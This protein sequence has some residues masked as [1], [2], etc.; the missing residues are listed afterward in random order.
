[1]PNDDKLSEEG[2]PTRR[3]S[4]SPTW[5]GTVMSAKD[6]QIEAIKELADDKMAFMVDRLDAEYKERESR[7]AQL[8]Q[9]SESRAEDMQK[10]LAGK[11]VT[12]KRLWIVIVVQTLI[13]AALAGVTVTGKLPF[14]GDINLDAAQGSEK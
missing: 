7:S 14:I 6:A 12:V 11:D 1:M 13:I 3:R 10:S 9:M 2:Q 5:V 4:K 8:Y